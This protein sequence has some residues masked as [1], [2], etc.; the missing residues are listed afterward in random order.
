MRRLAIINGGK[1]TPF[2]CESLN[3]KDYEITEWEIIPFVGDYDLVFF[4]LDET[5]DDKDISSLRQVKKLFLGY[6]KKF[7]CKWVVFA[8]Q[9]STRIRKRGV[10]KNQN[11]AI[12]DACR[13]N[14]QFKKRFRVWSSFPI[15]SVLCN[16]NCILARSS[17][18]H[19]PRTW[20]ERIHEPMVKRQIE[21]F[22]AYD[23][24]NVIPHDL[25][26][27]IVEIS[28]IEENRFVETDG[29]EYGDW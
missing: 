20:K 5:K 8:P 17:A 15:K 12:L 26:R 4:F 2:I 11:R 16:R 10:M 23:K 13:F 27:H 14:Y 24:I 7:P 1:Y 29:K 21:L 9:N 6:V 19:D 22:D 3:P 18:L 25:I 28:I